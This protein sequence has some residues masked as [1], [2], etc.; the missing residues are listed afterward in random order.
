MLNLSAVYVARD[1]TVRGLV[2]F[3]A[4]TPWRRDARRRGATGRGRRA[5]ARAPRTVPAPAPRS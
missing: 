2:G 1:R 3:D 4:C 5:F